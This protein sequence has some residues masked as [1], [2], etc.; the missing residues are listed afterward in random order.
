[1]HTYMHHF[2][3][4]PPNTKITVSF[5]FFFSVGSLSSE[6]HDFDPTAEMLIHEYDDERTLEEE[7]LLDG[8]KNFSAELSDLERVT[9][10]HNNPIVFLIQKCMHCVHSLTPYGLHFCCDTFL[11]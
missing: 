11:F 3:Q 7:E 9:C 2:Y 8:E 6:D 5:H 1:M 10:F 4:V